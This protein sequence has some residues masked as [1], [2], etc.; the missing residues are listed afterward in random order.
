VIPEAL[1]RPRTLGALTVAS[2]LV[3]VALLAALPGS[4]ATSTTPTF[5]P[6]VYVDQQLAGGEP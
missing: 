6:P 3:S 1:R 4:A 5:A 2:A